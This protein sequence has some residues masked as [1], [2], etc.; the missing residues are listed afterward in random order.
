MLVSDMQDILYE[1][2]WISR[3]RYAGISYEL[4]CYFVWAMLVSYLN[5]AGISY[6]ICWYLVWDMLVS[7]T[8]CAGISYELCWYLIWA[9]LVSHMRYAVYLVRDMLVSRLSSSPVWASQRTASPSEWT[10]QSPVQSFS[11][12]HFH[13]PPPTPDPGSN[14]R[15]AVKLKMVTWLL[16]DFLS[17]L[18]SKVSQEFI[19]IYLHTRPMLKHQCL[20]STKTRAPQGAIQKDVRQWWGRGGVGIVGMADGGHH[21]LLWV[22]WVV[23]TIVHWCWSTWFGGWWSL[24]YIGAGQYGMVDGGHY[25]M[26]AG[27]PASASGVIVILAQANTNLTVGK[28]CSQMCT[29][30]IHYIN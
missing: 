8:S 11:G 2:C 30:L 23:V 18:M 29:S 21:W 4:C 14:I 10:V 26:V 19:W 25:G 12:T 24:W 28:N 9:M 7:H 17:L 1:I 3:M 16:L 20:N 27:C 5:Y 13:S 15:G 6:E 22:W